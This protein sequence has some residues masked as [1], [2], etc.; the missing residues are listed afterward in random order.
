MSSDIFLLSPSLIKDFGIGDRG[1][2]VNPKYAK[3][4]WNEL[5]ENDEW[6]ADSPKPKLSL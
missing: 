1:A 3:L 2:Q 6:W 4:G 5:W